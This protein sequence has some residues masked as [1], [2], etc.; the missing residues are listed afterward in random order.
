MTEEALS[1]VE[2]AAAGEVPSWFIENYHDVEGNPDLE[3]FWADIQALPHHRVRTAAVY[4]L[5]N[6]FGGYCNTRNIPDKVRNPWQDGGCVPKA[7]VT[8]TA[9]AGNAELSLSW[10]APEYDGGSPIEGYRVQW[11]SASEEY[12]DTAASTRQAEV[13]DLASLAHTVP[14]LTNGLGYAVRVLA[15]NHYG[16]G[17]ASD[18]F[19]AMPT[20][21]TGPDSPATGAPTISGTAQ[22]GG[23]LTVETSAI[24]DADGL[25]NVSYSFKWLADDTEIVGATDPTYTLVDDDAGLTIKVKV[26]FFDDKNNPETLTSVATAAVLA[27][28]PDA[29][30]HLNVSLHDTGALDV[31]WEAPATD[32]GSAITGYK[33]QWKSG[34]EDY[35]GSAGS[36]RQA[37]ITDPA[38][39]THTITG[40]TD[41][42]E[43]AVRI[44]AVNDVGDGPSSTEATGTPRETNPPVLTGATVASVALQGLTVIVSGAVL[45]LTYDEALDEN[46][47]PA[48]NAFTVTVN[49]AT[50][51][52][53]DVSVSGSE[54]TL[55]LDSEITSE[56]TVA[57]SYTAPADAAA[58]RIQDEAGNPAASF[59]NQAVVNNTPAANTP[60]T[61]APTISGTV[62][63]GETLTA[64]ISGIDDADGLNNVS[65]GYQWLADDTEI[66]GATDPTYTLAAAHVGRTIK[67]RVNFT[68]DGNNQETLTSGATAAVASKP[69]SPATGALT[70]DGMAQ[71]GKTLTAVTSGIADTDGLTNVSFSYQWLADDTD[72]SSVTSDSYT[73]V[74][75]DEGKAIKVQVSFSDDANNQETLTSVATAAVAA[76]A[77]D[78]GPITGFTVVDASDQSLEGTLVD[79]GT[80]GGVVKVRV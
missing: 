68:D 18:E 80:L 25:D 27:N 72:I 4:Q 63:V 44:I 31:S 16:E 43:Y 17:A 13:T 64:D 76:A 48:A 40:L 37:E 46:S 3:E 41:G 45:T 30:E 33:V 60:S 79:G 34:S 23:T 39:R 66:A 15:Y 42:V 74:A 47:V 57:V 11:K 1:V 73:P 36:T 14:G 50:A 61:G 32:G 29:P 22:V 77:P 49:G 19:I 59:S 9:V 8:L 51:T 55:M 28:V 56:D 38:S 5:R 70:I 7:P 20:D 2:S 62:Q 24:D 58:P 12:D 10:E 6:E 69:N 78:P 54:V 75:A 67:V 53:N 71:V 21:S 52:V 26:S 35:D 65:F